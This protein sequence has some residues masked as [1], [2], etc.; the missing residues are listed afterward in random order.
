VKFAEYQANG[1]PVILTRGIG[2]V[3]DDVERTGDGVVVEID[4]PVGEQATRTIEAWRAGGW[5]ERREAIGRRAVERYSRDRYR[6][7]YAEVLARLGV[8][9][10]PTEDGGSRA[11]Y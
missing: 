3:S 7:A 10:S 8:G 5:R 9:V 6:T 1:L 11:V 4:A 2:D